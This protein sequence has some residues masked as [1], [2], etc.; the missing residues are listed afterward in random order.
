MPA[1]C[2][3][4]LP[5]LA[6]PSSPLCY[7]LLLLVGA[8]TLLQCS[9]CSSVAI[10]RK[11]RAMVEQA[12]AAG[13]AFACKQIV[14]CASACQTSRFGEGAE[15]R[16]TISEQEAKT[17]RQ[18]DNCRK[19]GARL[20]RACEAKAGLTIGSTGARQARFV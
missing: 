8:F 5:H 10:Q 20:E 6:A 4:M 13:Y 9:P 17:G 12:P 19:K 3:F 1:I 14:A 18:R 2:L 11:K 16:S 15:A 7:P